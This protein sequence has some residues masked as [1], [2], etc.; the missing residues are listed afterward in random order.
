MGKDAVGGELINSAL[1]AVW[2]QDRVHGNS[3][4]TVAGHGR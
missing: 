2:A 3:T 4:H 1:A